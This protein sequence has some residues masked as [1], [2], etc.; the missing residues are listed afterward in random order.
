MVP[1]RGWASRGQDECWQSFHEL[2]M[3]GCR[4]SWM[5]QGTSV[6]SSLCNNYNKIQNSYFTCAFCLTVW[7]CITGT[8]IP[9]EVRALGTGVQ[10]TVSHNVGAGNWPTFSAITSALNP[11]LCGSLPTNHNEVG[12]GAHAFNSSTWETSSRPASSMSGIPGQPD[13][14]RVPISS[15]EQKNYTETCWSFL[16]NA[17]FGFVVV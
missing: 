14:H 17:A 5:S 6:K 8:P 10:T 15:N 7:M 13:L 4:E 2:Q 16:D 3:C 11:H 9:E 1:T 12:V